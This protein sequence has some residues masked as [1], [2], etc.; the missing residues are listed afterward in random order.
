MSVRLSLS[1]HVAKRETRRQRNINVL[2]VGLG[3]GRTAS[4]SMQSINEN[5]GIAGSLAQPLQPKLIKAIDRKPDGS[6]VS[7]KKPP[8]DRFTPVVGKI[9]D[10][11]GVP[12]TSS[13]SSICAGVRDLWVRDVEHHHKIEREMD[14]GSFKHCVT[15]RDSVFEQDHIRGLQIGNRTRPATNLK[16]NDHQV[17]LDVKRGYHRILLCK[18]QANQQHGRG[19]CAT[20]LT[21]HIRET[22]EPS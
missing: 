22:L 14:G 12:K 20:G 11:F 13:S 10:G 8:C 2:T 3:N 1:L 5:L 15:A 21:D 6:L 9:N 19:D 18:A 16:G 17:G 4:Q 7:V